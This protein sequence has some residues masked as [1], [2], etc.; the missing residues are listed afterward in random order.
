MIDYS[1]A[2]PQLLTQG[3]TQSAAGAGTQRCPRGL[4]RGTT[5]H[6]LAR[7]GACRTPRGTA[8]DSSGR[9][10]SLRR[11]RRAR[12]STDGATNHRSFVAANLLPDGCSSGTTNRAAEGRASGIA[13]EGR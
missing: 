8:H 4:S 10:L 12:S 1:R 3:F 6:R 13:R 5:T 2:K 11:D 7:G 9:S